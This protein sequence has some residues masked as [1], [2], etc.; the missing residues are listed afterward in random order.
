MVL[1][2]YFLSFGVFLPELKK[3]FE[4]GSGEV[5]T[6][7]SIQM[8]VT[9]GSGYNITVT[10]TYRAELSKLSNL[11]IVSNCLTVW[12]CSYYNYEECQGQGRSYFADTHCLL[13]SVSIIITK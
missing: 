5:S 6:I 2:K 10:S 4:C 8:G 9:F 7:L 11:S 1:T 12:L 13:S 3:Y